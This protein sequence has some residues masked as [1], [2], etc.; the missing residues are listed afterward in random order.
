MIPWVKPA[1]TPA[2][3]TMTTNRSTGLSRERKSKTASSSNLDAGWRRVAA[4]ESDAQGSSADLRPQMV[5]QRPAQPAQRTLD[6]LLVAG[7]LGLESQGDGVRDPPL[8]HLLAAV[9]VEDPRVDQVRAGAA[10][11]HAQ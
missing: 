4:C 5:L 9:D 1:N 10:A 7:G 3:R 8:A 11:Q 2:A 6:L